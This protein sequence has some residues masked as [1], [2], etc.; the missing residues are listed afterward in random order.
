MYCDLSMKINTHEM[1]HGARR[2]WKHFV[3]IV[4]VSAC[5]VGKNSNTPTWSSMADN[6]IT[7]GSIGVLGSPF[8]TCICGCQ[9]VY[10][11]E[12][13]KVLVAT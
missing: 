3:C 7:W 6:A 8:Y 4:F 9:S 5:V 1:P 10:Y 2:S 13:F 11:K 12:M